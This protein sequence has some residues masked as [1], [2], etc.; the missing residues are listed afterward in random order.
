MFKRI[1]NNIKSDSGVS[2]T[3]ELLFMIIVLFGLLVTIIDFGLYFANRNVVT[4]SAQNGARLAAI[5]G[6]ASD[7][8]VSRQYG[9][10][11]VTSECSALGASNPVACSVFNELKETRGMTNVT[12]HRISC[13]P[14]RTSR[15]GERTWC[16]IDWSFQGVPGSALS[17]LSSLQGGRG[18][19]STTRMTAESE[20]VLR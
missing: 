7:T 18:W 1:K 5:Y 4:N 14:Y 15:I 8:S 9:T 19:Q 20:V 11:S 13:G 6:G 17:F 10:T 2:A 16:Q 12:I 3:V